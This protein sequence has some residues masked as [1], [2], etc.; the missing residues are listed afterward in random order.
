MP[1]TRTMSKRGSRELKCMY[2]LSSVMMRPYGAAC[3]Y[4]T[5]AVR[6]VRCL[7]LIRSTREIIALGKDIERVALK[8]IGHAWQRTDLQGK[9]IV[10]I[11]SILIG[12]NT[13]RI[14]R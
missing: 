11:P 10:V 8:D 5:A 4:Y 1:I 14:K 13:F 12:G 7:V 3:R 9:R 6:A 2:D